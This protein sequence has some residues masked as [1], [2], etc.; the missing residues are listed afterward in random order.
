VE[1]CTRPTTA[2][3]GSDVS[4]LSP[5]PESPTGLQNS[6]D[7]LRRGS[8]NPGEDSDEEFPYPYEEDEY[9]IL[10]ETK[11]AVHKALASKEPESGDPESGD[12]ESGDPELRGSELREPEPG[13]PESGEPESGGPESGEPES[14]AA[15]PEEN[16]DALQEDDESEGSQLTF[17]FPKIT[18]TSKFAKSFEDM[19]D[20]PYDGLYARV[21]NAQ[22]A[23]V[24]WQNEYMD[25]QR[26]LSPY[27][28][29]EPTKPRVPKPHLIGLGYE[30]QLESYI[31]GYEHNSHKSKLGEQKPVQQR[32]VRG[33]AAGRELR[34][35]VPTQRA[36]E[37]DLTEGPDSDIERGIDYGRPE[38]NDQD[39]VGSRRGSRIR[40]QTSRFNSESRQTPPKRTFPSGKP[41]GRPKK[42]KSK[43]PSGHR[44]A[45]LQFEHAS[46][47]HS[48]GYQTPTTLQSLRGVKKTGDNEDVVQSL[49]QDT[50]DADSRPGTPSSI[51]TGESDDLQGQSPNRIRK[52]QN[53]SDF[54]DALPASKR[55]RQ[56]GN[57]ESDKIKSRGAGDHT[58]INEN[59]GATK[60]VTEPSSRSIK[61][62]NTQLNAWAR[63]DGTR[64]KKQSE[65][66]K[67]RWEEKKALGYTTLSGPPASPLSTKSKTKKPAAKIRAAEQTENGETKQSAAS[68]NMLRRWAEKR[69]AQELGLP[70]PKIGRYA[71][72]QTPAST[73]PDTDKASDQAQASL[74]GAANKKRKRLVKESGQAENEE[75]T[76]NDPP[77]K[78]KRINSLK[79]S[80][81]TESSKEE[82]E[83]SADNPAL[84]SENEKEVED[85]V[86]NDVS[87]AGSKQKTRGKKPVEEC[88]PPTNAIEVEDTPVDGA[89]VIKA[90]GRS[91]KATTVT[92]HASKEVSAAE[93]GEETQSAQQMQTRT[94]GRIRRQTSAPTSSS[95]NN[96]R[97]SS[98]SSAKMTS[99]P[100]PGPHQFATQISGEPDQ[101]TENI[102]IKEEPLALPP[103]PKKRRGRGPNYEWVPIDPVAEAA[104]AENDR[105]SLEETPGKT[106]RTRQPK[107]TSD[108]KVATDGTVSIA[109]VAQGEASGKTKRS[110]TLKNTVN[111]APTAGAAIRDSIEAAQETVI[112]K[113]VGVIGAEIIATPL[114]T[115][116]PQKGTSGGLRSKKTVPVEAGHTSATNQVTNVEIIDDKNNIEAAKARA[117]KSKSEKM[118]AVMKGECNLLFPGFVLTGYRTLGKWPDERSHGKEEGK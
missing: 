54:E 62:K 53:T 21:E 10:P 58:K 114:Q 78:K 49:E 68:R 46:G 79:K 57:V 4:S 23:L 83:T 43:N 17:K 91:K 66:T 38:S 77:P 30:D 109:Q 64:R 20:L 76:E 3:S 50:D 73:T 26:L 29:R 42:E 16:Y 14:T 116:E 22:Q 35:R 55:I 18:D 39:N 48:N 47:L 28:E 59:S 72:G 5:P 97:R 37:A 100:T 88:S 11:I 52:R 80:V 70:V 40:N 27:D 93:A 112:E 63:D 94:S 60:E 9:D 103:M 115:V 108:G 102:A 81:N 61:M 7:G 44:I 25:L 41:I 82:A 6:G 74:K 13:E 107:I 85:S 51:M 86:S 87:I 1:T 113:G 98:H 8:S 111:N 117:K 69:R 31:Y 12:P 65:D 75:A 34:Q 110:R 45:E 99:T 89:A 19:E 101:L 106:R 118:S 104:A 95:Q 90:T 92:D 24:T 56:Q 96:T 67:K 15:E 36:T 105:V 32:I 33:P 84:G 2:N 71:K